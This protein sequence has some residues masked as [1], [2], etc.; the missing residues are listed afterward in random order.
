VDELV[1]VL[2]RSQVRNGFMHLLPIPPPASPVQAPEIL[3][4]EQL[5][6]Q[7]R[8]TK[9][10]KVEEAGTFFLLFRDAYAGDGEA[11]RVGKHR[12]TR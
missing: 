4:L 12:S 11:F 7:F 5:L 3:Q 10:A 1:S 8:Q 9:S 6:R 2:I